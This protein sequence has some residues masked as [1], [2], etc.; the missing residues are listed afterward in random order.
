MV[1]STWISLGELWVKIGARTGIVSGRIHLHLYYD[2][3]LYLKWVTIVKPISLNR[4]ILWLE[5]ANGGGWPSGIHTEVSMRALQDKAWDYFDE[6]K[7]MFGERPN[8][9]KQLLQP[10]VRIILTEQR[11][12]NLGDFTLDEIDGGPQ[13]SLGVSNAK[14]STQHLPR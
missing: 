5:D 7:L 1:D 8:F 11:S 9:D 10:G 13:N 4:L 2:R 14:Y 3:G 12:R 6:H